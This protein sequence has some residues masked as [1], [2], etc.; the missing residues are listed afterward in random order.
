VRNLRGYN[1]GVGRK[2]CFAA[3][4]CITRR[5][6]FALRAA[7]R[8]FFGFQCGEAV[9]RPYHYKDDSERNDNVNGATHLASE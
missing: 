4:V 6:A 2:R 7:V 5:K 3:V 8:G 1:L 9:E